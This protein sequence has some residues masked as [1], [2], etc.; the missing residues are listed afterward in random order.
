MRITLGANSK[1][2]ASKRT[3]ERDVRRRSKSQRVINAKTWRFVSWGS[4]P[5]G[6]CPHWGVHKGQVSFNPF[7]LSNDHKYL[8]SLLHYLGDTKSHNGLHR[9]NQSLLHHFYNQENEREKN[10]KSSNDH[11]TLQ[12]SN[13]LAAMSLKHKLIK[14]GVRMA[15]YVSKCCT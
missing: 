14:C 10:N 6:V 8:L 3:S 4:T 2:I 9:K 12:H 5:K 11:K 7:P 1:S 15:L 13:V